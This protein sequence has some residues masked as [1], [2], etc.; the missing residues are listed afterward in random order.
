MKKYPVAVR[1]TNSALSERFL[2]TVLQL[3][4]LLSDLMLFPRLA[5]LIVHSHRATFV[6]GLYSEKQGIKGCF[7]VIIISSQVSAS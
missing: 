2:A 6:G 7:V 3:S 4:C 1:K 5:K